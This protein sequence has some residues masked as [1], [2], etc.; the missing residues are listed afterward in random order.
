MVET[1]GTYGNDGGVREKIK[2]STLTLYK[3]RLSSLCQDN[4]SHTKMI[5]PSFL[6]SELCS[7]EFCKKMP[8]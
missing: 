8:L 6:V 1:L 4:V 2:Q 7:F 3:V 5:V